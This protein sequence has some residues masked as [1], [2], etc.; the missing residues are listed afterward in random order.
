MAISKLIHQTVADKNRLSKI[1]TDNINFLRELNPDW[2]H[3]LYDDNDIL[4][5][6]QDNYDEEILQRYRK[7]SSDYGAAKADYFRYLLL[8]KVG[9]VYLDIK[10]TCYKKLN[11]VIYDRDVFILSHWRNK[12]GERYQSYGIHGGLLPLGEYQTWHI[13]AAA[14]HRL[15]KEVVAAV[16]KNI[17]EYSPFTHGVGF[18]G[19]LRTTGPIAYTLAIQKAI[20]TADYRLVDIE[21]LGFEYSIHDLPTGTDTGMHRTPDHYHFKRSPV[22]VREFFD[23]L[24][25]PLDLAKLRRNDLCPCGSGGRFK[26]CH[27][28]M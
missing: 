10:S 20:N 18:S 1:Y 12:P 7:I 23:S 19:T 4:R 27:G 3:T 22:I 15:L 26:H 24:G 11:D 5:F 6:I 2:T 25:N 17:D 28:I 8:L 21:D 13:I 9:G 14:D 16:S